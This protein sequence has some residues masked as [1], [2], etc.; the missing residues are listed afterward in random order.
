MPEKVHQRQG[1][2]DLPEILFSLGVE[3]V[4]LCPGSR[5]APIT[6]SFV[7]FGRQKCI[8]IVDERSAAYFALGIVQ[9][10]MKP[11]A[12]VCT[13]GTAAL[14]FAPAVS[15]AYYQNLPLI[16]I[17]ADRPVE[18]VDQADSQTIRQKNLY[19]NYCKAS[20]DIPGDIFTADDLWYANRTVSQAVALSLTGDKGP[21]HLNIPLKEPLYNPL[22]EQSSNT[23]VIRFQ[24]N[25]F[26]R[27]ISDISGFAGNLNHFSKKWILLGVA[28]PDAHL[29]ELISS[30]AG[31]NDFLII[32]ENTSNISGDNIITTP[33][34][35]IA[36][37][38]ESEK[39]ILKPDLLITIGHSI[40]SKKL[41]IYL[42]NFAPAEHWQISHS[43]TMMD[44]FKCLSRVIKTDAIS[45]LKAIINAPVNKSDIIS[46]ICTDYRG[47]C[48]YSSAFLKVAPYS[49]LSCISFILNRLPSKSIV[50]LANSSPVR[51]SQISETRSDLNY[52][53]NRGTSGIDGCTSTAAGAAYSSENPVFLITGDLAFLY[54]SNALWN[55]YINKN[56]KIIVTNNNGGNIFSLIDTSPE[57]DV[58]KEYFSTPHSVNIS[59]LA[60]AYNF[61]YLS[62]KNEDELKSVFEKFLLTDKPTVLEIV[63][64]A[65][66]NSM[67]YKDYYK[68]I[69]SYCQI[70]NGH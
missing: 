39:E 60:E 23:S 66:H 67:V 32:T 69:A 2:R 63:T 42:R 48:N 10:S 13:S 19:Q 38:K 16:I 4:V 14:N 8:S 30:L 44:T 70:S 47:L 1:I 61:A 56:F 62:V 6:I 36:S 50:H 12:I 59:K 49:D 29:Q 41:K 5:S 40:V 33:D 55:N 25:I 34:T 43:V 27:E 65:E 64:N 24:E 9:F 31:R 7:K 21:V 53:C 15:E 3:N 54:D 20:F 46:K 68:Y 22:P 52:F 51:Y 26:D 57:M 17:T 18:W 35:W 11:V 37:L 58:A 28:T 45:F